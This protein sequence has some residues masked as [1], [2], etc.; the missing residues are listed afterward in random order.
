MLGTYSIMSD[1]LEKD[2]DPLESNWLTNWEEQNIDEWE[3]ETLSKVEDRIALEN[4]MSSKKLWQS[5]QN[6]ASSISQLYK[7][8]HPKRLIFSRP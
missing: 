5:F 2:Q 4:E 1:G 3:N 8:E 6:S 7:G